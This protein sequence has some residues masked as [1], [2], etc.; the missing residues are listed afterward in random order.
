V[1]GVVRGVHGAD[2]LLKIHRGGFSSPPFAP[3]TYGAPPYI[4]LIVP[5]EGFTNSLRNSY[6]SLIS[7][8]IEC[9][10]CAIQSRPSA[11]ERFREKGRTI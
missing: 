5:D 3:I 2:M 9:D 10:A 8:L 4:P 7:C 11:F 1:F 6:E